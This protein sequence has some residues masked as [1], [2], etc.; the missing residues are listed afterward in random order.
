MGA[1]FKA[2]H[3]RL[4]R[5]GCGSRS[6]LCPSH[7]T[8]RPSC[9]FAARSRPP[10]DLKH[11]NVV[12]AAQA[13]RRRPRRPFPGDGIRRR[14]CDLDHIVRDRGP[15]K[16][17]QAIDCVIQAAR[18]LEA[19]H[20]Q[21]IIHRDIKLRQPHAP[22]QPAPSAFSTSVWPA[23]STPPILFGKSAGRPLDR[24]RKCTWAQST[25]WPPNRPK[26]S[27]RVDHRADIYS[28]RLHQLYFLAQ[29]P[30]AFSTGDGH[31]LETTGWPTWSR[32]A[33][34]LYAPCN[35]PEV[36]ASLE[37]IYQKMMAKKP[38]ERPGL[39]GPS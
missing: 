10:A 34:P 36:P 33:P 23:W 25:S 29:R 12:A 13:C 9:D 19:A 14:P 30:R 28:L 38:A 18:G 7:A 15:T 17:I 16:A 32:P 1:V 8:I 3:R 6:S 26:T 39:D 11:P 5:V 24:K 2:R 20:A 31:R 35:A 37:A 21:G 27:H 22:T 4:G